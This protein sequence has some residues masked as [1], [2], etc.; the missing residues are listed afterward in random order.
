MTFVRF[1]GLPADAHPVEH[2]FPPPAES[3]S[4]PDVGEAVEWSG[5]TWKVTWRTW[6]Y[7]DDPSGGLSVRIN[8]KLLNND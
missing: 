6:N 1:Q 5:C 3:G 8:L 4:V 2:C 7:Y